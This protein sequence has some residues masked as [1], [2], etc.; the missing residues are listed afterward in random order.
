MFK[1]LSMVS[2]LAKEIQDEFDKLEIDGKGKM[3]REELLEIIDSYHGIIAGGKIK[4]DYEIFNKAKKLK[5]ITMFG[6]GID[7]VDLEAASMCGVRVTNVPGENAES[8][9]EHTIGL[10][11]AASKN[12]ATVDKEIRAGKWPREK[13][14]GYELANKTLG[15][16]GF[17]NIGRLVAQKC[18]LAFNMNVIV[19][20][21]Y[22]PEYEV[23]NLAYRVKKDLDYLLKNSDV[24]SLNLPETEE[25]R[26]MFAMEQFEKMK[27]NA[28]LV[29]SGRGKVI[30][31]KDLVRA[32]NKNEIF[33]VGLDVMETEPP[34]SDNPLLK[35]ERVIFTPHTASSTAE[36]RKRVFRA[37]LKDQE[38][39]FN[40]QE[41]YFLKNPS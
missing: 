40:G 41:P 29:N 36:A 15:Q 39:I 8:V 18:N 38:L 13:G 1:I 34:S 16:V 14:F 27:K 19:Y 37:V 2:R 24:I 12:F 33:A 35:E 32:L 10:I 7:N 11:I 23:N 30:V 20:D 3:S 31:E 28:V 4:Y 17:G 26:G 6:V 25:T 5:V 22:V 21:P 9:A